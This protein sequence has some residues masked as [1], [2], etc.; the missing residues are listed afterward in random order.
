[1]KLLVGFTVAVFCASFFVIQHY[2][3]NKPIKTSEDSSL[4]AVEKADL[5]SLNLLS[6]LFYVD[7]L[8]TVT[9]GNFSYQVKHKKILNI[10]LHSGQIVERN[11]IDTEERSFCLKAEVLSQLNS[12]LTTSK[13]C[14]FNKKSAQAD[15]MCAQVVRSPYLEVLSSTESFQLGSASDSCGSNGVDLCNHE[16]KLKLLDITTALGRTYQDMKCSQ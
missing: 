12:V 5:S 7:S 15:Q 10:N 4:V 16:Q 11:D 13:V 6:V 1:M 2:S 3:Q 14:Q 9:K 8:K